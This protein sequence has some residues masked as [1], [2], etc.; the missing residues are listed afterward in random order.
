M[1]NLDRHISEAII[2]A[3][4]L[5]VKEKGLSEPEAHRYL[6]KQAMDQRVKIEVVAQ[7]IVERA[8]QKGK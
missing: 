1:R 8:K 3:K 6:Q 4:D 7:G 5:I 2:Q